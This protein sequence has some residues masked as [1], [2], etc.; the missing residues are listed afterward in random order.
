MNAAAAIKRRAQSLHSNLHGLI[1]LQSSVAW[2]NTGHG[3]KRQ[4]SDEFLAW[5]N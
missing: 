4:P 2:T 5:T 3:I 1:V